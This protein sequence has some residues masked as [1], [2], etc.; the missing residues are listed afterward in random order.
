MAQL[1]P[2][3]E[4]TVWQRITDGF[5]ESL[6]DLGEGITDLFVWIAVNSPYLVVTALVLVIVIATIR[7]GNRKARIRKAAK[8]T[9]VPTEDTE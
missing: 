8:N 2:T 5:Q 7:R 6:T 1:T 4:P 3:E 9:T